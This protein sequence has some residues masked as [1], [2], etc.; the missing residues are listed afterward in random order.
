MIQVKRVYGPPE[1]SHGARILVDRVWPQRVKKGA[2][3]DEWLCCS[4]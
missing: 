1:A 4:P 2:A 3:L